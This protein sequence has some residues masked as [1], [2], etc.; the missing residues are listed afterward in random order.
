LKR[1]LCTVLCLAALACADEGDDE[2]QLISNVTAAPLP[3]ESNTLLELVPLDADACYTESNELVPGFR[4]LEDARS[5]HDAYLAARPK[6]AQVPSIDFANYVVVQAVVG[7]QGG[8]GAAVELT[9]AVNRSES[10]EV[11][12]RTSDGQCS[13]PADRLSFAFAF[14]QVN[15]LAKPYT[16]VDVSE[17][18]GSCP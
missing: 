12:V 3:F 7:Q 14:A 5:F 13:A 18:S 11:E 2:T 6:A 9:S 8:C 16:Q 4:V 15:R 17:A 1:T 10:V